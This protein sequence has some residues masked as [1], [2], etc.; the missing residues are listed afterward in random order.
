MNLLSMIFVCSTVSTFTLVNSVQAEEQYHHEHGHEHENHHREYTEHKAH[1]HGAAN[2]QL[3]ILKDEVLMQV[4]SP[5]FNMLGFEHQANNKQQKKLFTQQ[6]KLI[7]QT[8]LIELDGKAQCV[9][10]SQKVQHPFENAYAHHNH[11]EN[12]HR[13]ISFEY[14]FHCKEASNLKQINTEKLFKTWPHL[15]KLRVEWIY[16][17]Q[18]SAAELSREIPVLNFK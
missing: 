9:L 8:N 4:E 2:M 7:E 5:L 12:K 6:L 18:Q 10:D 13:D 17:N 16:Q 3:M 15:H 14:H 1:E 11:D